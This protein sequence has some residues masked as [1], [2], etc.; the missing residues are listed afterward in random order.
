MFKLTEREQGR[1]VYA[2]FFFL[3]EKWKIKYV[4]MGLEQD[5]SRFDQQYA[6][7]LSTAGSLDFFAIINKHHN[8]YSVIPDIWNVNSQ[9]TAS[10]WSQTILS[11]IQAW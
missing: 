1:Y 4:P 3:E 10:Q 5:G 7:F 6:F 11:N 9:M 2:I 8:I